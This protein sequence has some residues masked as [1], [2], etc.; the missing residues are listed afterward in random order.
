MDTSMK[1]LPDAELEIML[2]VWGHEEAVTA[3]EILAE[4]TGRRRWAL[5]TL[6]T[7]LSRLC[8][9]GFL[10]CEKQ[11]RSNYYTA[12]IE[13]ESYKQQESRNLLEKLH[14]N[15][16]QSLVASLYGGHAIDDADIEALRQYLN[17][18]KEE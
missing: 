18:L 16:V 10:R 3:S 4:L 6:M 7:V 9:K 11:G 12:L 5:A 2:V 14:G 15:S 17:D 1:R 13:E 8:E